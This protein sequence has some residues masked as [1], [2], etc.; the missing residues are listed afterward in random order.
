MKTD[1]SKGRDGSPSRPVGGRLPS[2]S[3][4]RL[5]EASLPK[6][7]LVTDDEAQCRKRIKTWFGMMRN[8]GAQM[9]GYRVLIG[10]ELNHAAETMPHGTFEK[11]VEEEFGLGKSTQ[12]YWRDFSKLFLEEVQKKAALPEGGKSPTVGLSDDKSKGGLP[13]LLASPKAMK[14][15]KG[16]KA[17]LEIA[18]QI[19]DGKGMMQFCRELKLLREPTPAGGD[20]DTDHHKSHKPNAQEQLES[21]KLTIESYYQDVATMCNDKEN[22]TIALTDT[23]GRRQVEGLITKLTE[24]REHLTSLVKSNKQAV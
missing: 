21:A 2:A 10:A 15:K 13:P 4:G 16:L 17:I 5:G 8:A 14:S 22:P 7:E 6:L 19:M 18:P 1:L 23:E 11:W 20:R 9:I 24:A 12:H 3:I